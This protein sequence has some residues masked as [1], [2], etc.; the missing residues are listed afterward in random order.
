MKT[1]KFKIILLLFLFVQGVFLILFFETTSNQPHPKKAEQ[2]P[3]GLLMVEPSVVDFGEVSTEIVTGKVELVNNSTETVVL[4]Y[5][6]PSCASCTEVELPQ[7]EILPGQRIP[8]E[9]RSDMTSKSGNVNNTIMVM[10][11][12]KGKDY[13]S[14]LVIPI[15]AKVLPKVVE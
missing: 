7:Q 15:F 6:V 8:L 4:K 14:S 2:Q 9:F 1:P 10:Y 5:A 12:I 3:G 11:E 13:T